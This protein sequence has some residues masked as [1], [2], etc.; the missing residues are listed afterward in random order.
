MQNKR[1]LSDV[2]KPYRRWTVNSPDRKRSMLSLIPLRALFINVSVTLVLRSVMDHSVGPLTSFRL[3]GEAPRNG[4]GELIAKHERNVWR[5]DEEQY[6]RVECQGSVSIWFERASTTSRR[7]G[8]HHD[9]S[10]YDGVAY[11]GQHVFASLTQ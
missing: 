11:V 5:I 3:D 8:P 4:D 7:F 9:L 2:C 1:F 6:P 10:L